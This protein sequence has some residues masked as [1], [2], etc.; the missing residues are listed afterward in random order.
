MQNSSQL[1]IE[2]YNI[3]SFD[4]DNLRAVLPNLCRIEKKVRILGGVVCVCVCGGGAIA[5]WRFTLF[6]M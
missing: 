3:Q 6:S 4:N 2:L 1:Y 5:I